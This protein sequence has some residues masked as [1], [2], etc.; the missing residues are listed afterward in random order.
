[1]LT[2]VFMLLNPPAGEWENYQDSCARWVS[3]LLEESIVRD[4]E[5]LREPLRQA[6]GKIPEHLQEVLRLRFGL[7]GGSA[8]TLEQVGKQ[9][10][11]T[12][13]RVRQKECKALRMLRHPTRCSALRQL[14]PGEWLRG[15][16][17][18][19]LEAST[20]ST[21]LLLLWAED[22]KRLDWLE[23]T[24]EQALASAAREAADDK[25]R[26]E[27]LQSLLTKLYR[28]PITEVGLSARTVNALRRH[29]WMA[30]T[31]TVGEVAVLTERELLNIR[32]LG[33]K[34]LQEVRQRIR[35]VTQKG[36]GRRE[37]SSHP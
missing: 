15:R 2:E 25:R 19:V 35:E 17:F 20:I 27:Y 29:P 32:G 14:S 10:G 26:V 18:T 8:Q 31:P 12:R 13:E 6:L 28:T 34:T 1:M 7:D 16:V 22:R 11:V 24:R 37:E 4:T 23:R 30:D 5:I 21:A 3:G 33:Q 36:E 9:L